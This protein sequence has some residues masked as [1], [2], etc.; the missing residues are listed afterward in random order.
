MT[1]KF[2]RPLQKILQKYTEDPVIAPILKDVSYAQQGCF[3][4]SKDVKKYM[5]KFIYEFG[6]FLNSGNKK[7][8]FK[9]YCFDERMSQ[10]ESTFKLSVPGI[11]DNREIEYRNVAYQSKEFWEEI[12]KHIDD[13]N[14]VL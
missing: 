13:L 3:T 2:A 6:S 7:S 9:C 5:L 12:E 10:I 11:K 1:N 4:F 14:Y 8:A